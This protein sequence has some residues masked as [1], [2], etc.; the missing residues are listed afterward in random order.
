ML[1]PF[2]ILIRYPPNYLRLAHPLTRTLF[3]RTADF[4]Q[5]LESGATQ[6]LQCVVTVIP[7]F[8][9]W[10]VVKNSKVKYFN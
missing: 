1:K 10:E 3:S 5:V 6:P 4:M 8:S 2:K 7:G 9:Q